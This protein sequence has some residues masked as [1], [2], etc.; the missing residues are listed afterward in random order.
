MQSSIMQTET[1]AEFKQRHG[2][3]YQQLLGLMVLRRPLQLGFD[4]LYIPEVT[5]EE[6]ESIP[7]MA[8]RAQSALNRA[9][10]PRTVFGRAEFLI[11]YSDKEH[12]RLVH[13]GYVK[14]ADEVQPEFRQVLDLQPSLVDI[15]THMKPKGRYNTGLAEKKG[16]T[17]TFDHSDEAIKA[18]IQLSHATAARKGFAGR[19][20]A[21]LTDLISWLGHH[22][23]GGLAVARFEGHILAAAVVSFYSKRGSY[24]YGVSADQHREVM[25]PY[26][27]HFRLIEEAKRRGCTQYDLIGVAPPDAPSSHSWAGISRFKREF[28]GETIQYLGSY[29]RVYRPSVYALY[30]VARRK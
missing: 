18:F 1:W 16:V 21:Y 6:G 13:A 22:K 12:K 4:F 3:H 26:L 25:A 7:A 27:L 17:V 2:W 11:P 8:A 24:L 10:T 20:D 9:K 28:G 23:M 14:A 29:D 30:R 5:I 19:S 15:K